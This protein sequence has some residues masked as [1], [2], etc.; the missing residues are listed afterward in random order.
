MKPSFAVARA[1]GLSY[2]GDM[3]NIYLIG[4]RGCGKTT[5]GKKLADR[6]E[7]PFVDTD[8]VFLERHGSIA[9]FVARN[10]WDAFRDAEAEILETVSRDSGT[11]VGCGGGIVLRESNRDL[12][13]KG[14]CV[15]LK[16]SADE[17]TRRLKA[18]PSEG[19]RPS[20]T[21]QRLDDEVRQ[22]LQ[23]REP[24]YFDCA[25]LVM[26]VSEPWRIADF[27]AE[28]VRAGFF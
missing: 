13:R 10:G 11:V 26:K 2:F 18:D 27:V 9:D 15:Y 28:K 7:I 1:S 24:L 4:P 8:A 16:A 17:L 25:N 3:R 22:V 21:D 6:L 12:L 5:I 20:L 23:E 14:F 19:Q